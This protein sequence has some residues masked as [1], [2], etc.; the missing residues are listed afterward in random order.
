MNGF[1]LILKKFKKHYYSIIIC[2]VSLMAVIVYNSYSIVNN[3]SPDQALKNNIF[4]DLDIFALFL[5]FFGVTLGF[6]YYIFIDLPRR[7]PFSSLSWPLMK[8]ILRQGRKDLLNFVP[9]FLNAWIDYWQTTQKRLRILIRKTD[10]L[11]AHI[12]Q[13][14]LEQG[15]S[16]PLKIAKEE[17]KKLKES[18]KWGQ[19]FPI[20]GLVYAIFSYPSLSGA[21]LGIASLWF[22]DLYLPL[23]LSLKEKRKYLKF[24]KKFHLDSL[25]PLVVLGLLLWGMVT[26]DWHSQ[27]SVFYAFYFIV[28]GSL[29]I[30]SSYHCRN[31]VRRAEQGHQAQHK[32]K[33]Y[34]LEHGYPISHHDL[35]II[36]EQGKEKGD[37]DF[38]IF[39]PQFPFVLEVK[40]FKGTISI[41]ETEIE[42]ILQPMLRK[43]S[44]TLRT[45]RRRRNRNRNHQPFPGF[46]RETCPAQKLLADAQWFQREWCL[47]REPICIFVFTYESVNLKI[48]PQYR[49][50]EKE[51][52]HFNGAWF[53]RLDQLDDLFKYLSS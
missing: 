39:H 50:G 23:Y 16:N 7:I 12:N 37:I 53:V 13:L 2:L 42:G 49:V 33:L 47:E 45:G 22:L 43:C 31:R 8:A 14:I 36:D 6:I 40:D 4:L 20:A 51:F 48:D 19:F 46:E 11:S 28:H 25:V 41:E 29:C 17:L 21:Y 15:Q 52:F 38:V 1:Q 3:L 44:R 34:L 10:R 32:V 30:H 35:E 18:E 5:L 26:G 27:K 9:D 24:Y